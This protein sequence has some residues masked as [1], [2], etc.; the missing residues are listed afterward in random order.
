MRKTPSNNLRILD[1][2]AINTTMP[3]YDPISE[4]AW[5]DVGEPFGENLTRSFGKTSRKNA[6]GAEPA[7]IG[8]QLVAMD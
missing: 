3:G 7:P 2:A 1:R 4:A 6:I 8:I 5:Q